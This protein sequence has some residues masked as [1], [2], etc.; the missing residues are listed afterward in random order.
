M[1]K[2]EKQA[3]NASYYKNN[4]ERL[5]AAQRARGRGLNRNVGGTRDY[6]FRTRYGITLAERTALWL[7]QDC[8]CAI[9]AKEIP[10]SGGDTHTD[11][12]H[13]TGEV[14]GILCRLCN[15]GLGNFDDDP[16]KLRAAAAY[17]ERRRSK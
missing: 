11:H 17:L 4:R 1:T 15:T 16:D 6:S 9:C 13:T 10:E 14:R 3:Y 7:A 8:R 12:D 5:V 2:D